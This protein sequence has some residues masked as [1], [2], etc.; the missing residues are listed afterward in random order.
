M[1]TLLKTEQDGSYRRK[2]FIICCLNVGNGH[3]SNAVESINSTHFYIHFQAAVGVAAS[4][5]LV[6]NGRPKTRE[7]LIR[8]ELRSLKPTA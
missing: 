5:W 7:R 8:A 2:I 4:F 3:G 1:T 6:V